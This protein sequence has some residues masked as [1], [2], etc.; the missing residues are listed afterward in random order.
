MLSISGLNDSGWLGTGSSEHQCGV[1]PLPDEPG[2]ANFSAWS[3]Q[4][5]SACPELCNLAS[6]LCMDT[7]RNWQRF[8]H[9]GDVLKVLVAPLL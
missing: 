8:V 6:H 2:D 1:Y 3:G 5:K 9:L 7:R 4:S